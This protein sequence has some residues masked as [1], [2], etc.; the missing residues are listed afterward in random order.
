MCYYSIVW[1]IMVDYCLVGLMYYIIASYSRR[2]SPMP[3]LAPQAAQNILSKSSKYALFDPCKEYA[4]I[5]SEHVCVCISPSLS[6]YIYIYIERERYAL[7]VC[8]YT[9]TYDSCL[10]LSLS[11]SDGLKTN[12]YI[13]IYIYQFRR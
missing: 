9:C 3:M 7:C 5:T 13:Y 2:C 12:I 10:S 6:L 1:L 4:C 11:L 8:N